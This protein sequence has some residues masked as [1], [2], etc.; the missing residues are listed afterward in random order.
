[1][2]FLASFT[3]LS[4]DSGLSSTASAWSLPEGETAILTSNPSASAISIPLLDAPRPGF[5]LVKSHYYF[6]RQPF[7]KPQVVNS[8]G[9]SRHGCGIGDSGLMRHYRVHL[10]FHDNTG[11]F[12]L[13]RFSLCQSRIKF[14]ICRKEQSGANLCICRPNRFPLRRKSSR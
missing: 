9:R 8:Q 13:F 2:T 6:I 5:V 7:Y 1:M 10:P 4:Q 3:A 14:W 12:F 11:V